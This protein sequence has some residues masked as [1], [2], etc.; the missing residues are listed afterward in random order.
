MSFANDVELPEFKS[1]AVMPD[2]PLQFSPQRI[3]PFQPSCPFQPE[4]EFAK[5]LTLESLPQIPIFYPLDKTHATISELST[6]VVVAN[7]KDCLRRLSIQATYNSDKATINAETNEHNR[8]D[9]HFYKS[10]SMPDSFIVELHCLSSSSFGFRGEIR[11][12]LESAKGAHRRQTPVKR[13]KSVPWVVPEILKDH[14]EIDQ[15]EVGSSAL[16]EAAS[17]LNKDRHD[18]NE[19]GIESMMLLT[20]RTTTLELIALMTAEAVVYGNDAHGD[21]QSKIYNLVACGKMYDHKDC[22]DD[23]IICE[24]HHSRMRRGALTVLHHSLDTISRLTTGN[25]HALS[26]SIWCRE[27]LCLALLQDLKDASSKP[28]DAHLATKCLNS[29]M[30]FCDQFRELVKGIYG[31][32]GI[33]ERA[34]NIG[35]SCHALLCEES[36]HVIK[37]LQA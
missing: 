13:R 6:S 32:H 23:D 15:H 14:L 34:L 7:I 29:M 1:A 30:K 9:I 5:K 26:D 16:E 12:I 37:T 8:F 35:R 36:A 19:L 28:H 27:S 17:L 22:L 10:V 31:V 20:D 25:E 4:E 21:L 11:T 24:A 2:R 33:L 3:L 18:A